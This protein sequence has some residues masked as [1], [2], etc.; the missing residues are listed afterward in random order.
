MILNPFIIESA[1]FDPY[2]NL[3]LEQWLLDHLKEHQCILYLWQNENT[4][5]IGKNQNAWK[6]CHIQHLKE[7]HGKLARRLSGGGAVYHD[8]GNLN[9][10]FLTRKEDYD[11]IRQLK[12]I[13][14]AL[15]S[16]GVDSQISGRN[17]LCVGQRKISGNA[18]FT[19]GNRCC[20]HGTLLVN[21]DREKMQL[22]LNP[23]KLKLASKNVASVR[24]RTANLI[25]FNQNITIDQLKSS[26]FSTFEQEYGKAKKLCLSEGQL[27]EI[28]QLKRHYGSEQWIL[29][30]VVDAQIQIEKRFEWG[31]I[32]I[33]VLI[34]KH[35]IQKVQIFTDCMETDLFIE[36]SRK[37]EK[38]QYTVSAIQVVF[39]TMK[40][41]N[42][43]VEII[44]DIMTC[45]IQEVENGTL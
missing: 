43:P 2:F 37:L 22:V 20:H 21:T 6:E 5:V 19:K 24:S 23:S 34:D 31:E 38:V 26:I 13:Q 35:V 18:F 33:F 27:E 36:I 17:D 25:E 4:V 29:N 1:D 11:V 10:T 39:E 15:A 41:R 40:N 14:Q 44:Q 12:V 7:N 28:N 3:A 45:F 16:L 32:L 9:F 30:F 42:H 8:L